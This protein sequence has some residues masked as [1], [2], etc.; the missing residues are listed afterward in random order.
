MT[1]VP[2][3]TIF[4]LVKV[5]VDEDTGAGIEL[6]GTDDLQP[7]KTIRTTT[8]FHFNAKPPIQCRLI[9]THPDN[10]RTRSMMSIL[11]LLLLIQI[12]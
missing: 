8:Y 3:T 11:L 1:W 7:T 12:Q 6:V 2:V 5:G 4:A 9:R 10:I